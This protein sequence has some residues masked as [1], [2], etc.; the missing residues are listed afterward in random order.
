M[1][2]YRIRAAVVLAVVFIAGESTVLTAGRLEG[3]LTKADGGGVPGVAIVVR[4]TS[5]STV[6]DASGN[7]SFEALPAG[8]YTLTFS[9]ADNTLTKEAVAVADGD[10]RR[11]DLTLDW[12]LR[13][14]DT[15]TVFSASRH[16]ER[17]IEA[18]ASVSVI[19]EDRI[20]EESTQGQL[21]KLLA[22]APGIEM[23][24]SGA[25]DFNINVRGFN[26]TLNRRVLVLLDGRDPGAVMLGAQEWGAY[27]VQPDNLAR[28]ELVRGPGS[29]LYGSNAFNGVVNFISK[30]PRYAQGGDLHLTAGERNTVAVSASQAGQ[31]STKTFFRVFGQATRGDDYFQ[32]RVTRVEYPGLALEVMAPPIDHTSVVSGGARLDRYFDAGRL[33][34]E[35]GTARIRGSMFVTPIGR[36][37]DDS[38][39]RPWA[40]ASFTT[41]PWNVSGFFDGRYGG[42]FGLANGSEGYDQS[43]KLHADVLRRLDLAG[44]KGRVLGG[45]SFTYAWIDSKDPRGIEQT[46]R[47]AESGRWGGLFGQ[48]DYNLTPQLKSVLALRVD[49]S[50]L[51]PTQLSPKAGLVYAIRPDQTI[52]VSVGHAF[53]SASFVE[54]FVRIPA[55]PPIDL[56][57]LEQALAPVVG[58]VP[59]QF[60]NVPVLVVGNDHLKVETV[61]SAEVGYTG[62]VGRRV[63]VSADYYRSRLDN[64][65]SSILPQVGT[66]FGRVNPD[67]GPYQ[68][69]AGLSA[70][71][72]A[73]VIGTL[74]SVLPPTLFPFL[75]NDKD[76]LPAFIVGSLT[77]YGQVDTQGL[78]LSVQYLP[79]HGLSA[80]LNY[81][82]FDFTVKHDQPDEPLQANSSPRRVHAGIGYSNRQVTVAFQYR[83]SDRFKWAQGLLLGDVPSYSVVDAAAE[84]HLTKALSVR[85]DVANLLD[86]RHYEV[87][88]GDLLRRRALVDFIAHW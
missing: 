69:P 34:V 15:L 41:G 9:L 51:H 61:T 16:T 13:Y 8:T 64:F 4:E 65:I 81:S 70:Q 24:Q 20:A 79:F 42:N 43:Y 40:R 59:L 76:G 85:L 10:T 25:Y 78:D 58:L 46:F 21:P 32:S 33:V 57:P 27:G 23:V 84:R 18:P 72:Q 60:S 3:R 77:N 55:A 68:P 45:G 52:R 54:Y 66:S 74:R 12:A 88:G 1:S 28:I 6:S 49:G 19:A 26:G 82:W 39:K 38:V 87:F 48:F 30:E 62:V 44:G 11:L 53:Q 80:N 2:S 14:S 31:L 86:N 83:W 7:Y 50:S 67:Y 29:A 56:A 35:G 22:S 63:I 5:A 47:Q 37:Q 71:Q 73:V 36:T 75:S 17:L